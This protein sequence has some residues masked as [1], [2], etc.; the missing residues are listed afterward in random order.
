MLL[1]E[2]LKEHREA[3]EQEHKLA[4]QDSRLHRNATIRPAKSVTAEQW[5]KL[6][7]SRRSIS[8]NLRSY[9]VIAIL[10]WTPM[11]CAPTSIP[12]FRVTTSA[13]FSAIIREPV[14]KQA[15]YN[16]GRSKRHRLRPNNRLMWRR[17]R[18][19][20][21]PLRLV[22]CHRISL[23][24]LA[25]WTTFFSLSAACVRTCALRGSLQSTAYTS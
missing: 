22:F 13:R 2:F 10:P 19:D 5:K 16:H 20:A 25:C 12:I 15:H 7:H 3:E 17:G 6:R 14:L 11:E 4:A 8:K 1:N 18:E 23:E 9:P 21:F 24:A